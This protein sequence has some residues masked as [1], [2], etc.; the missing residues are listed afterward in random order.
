MNY[1]NIYKKLVERAKNRT[2]EDLYEVHH[3]IPRCLGGNNEKENLVKL[4]PEEHYVAHQLLH[5]IYPDHKGLLYAAV[6]MCSNRMNNKLYGWL[7]R[8]LSNS[9]SIKMRGTGNN[10]YNKRWVSNDHETILVSK[11]QALSLIKLGSH[12]AG[13]I[14]V[15]DKCGHLVKSKCKVC[16][17][18]TRDY[19]DKKVAAAKLLANDLYNKFLESKD[20]SVTQFAK[21]LKT[22]QPRLTMLWKK[23]VPEYNQN[24]KHGKVYKKI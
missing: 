21:S 12:I 11:K 19:H 9:Q 10:L 1:E 22:S 16:N 15:K 5:K 2:S 14:A 18:K 6:K 23:Y 20:V 13:K 24:R 17:E 7:R 3:I 4:T 8:K